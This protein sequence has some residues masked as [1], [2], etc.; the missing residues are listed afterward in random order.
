MAMFK[1]GDRVI[2]ENGLSSLTVISVDSRGQCTTNDGTKWTAAGRK[3]GST[4]FNF[5]HISLETPELLEKQAQKVQARVFMQLRDSII[6]RVQS[7]TSLEKLKA[8]WEA[9]K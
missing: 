7:C 1:V 8:A 5:N 6:R 2:E 9:L 4:S 3:F